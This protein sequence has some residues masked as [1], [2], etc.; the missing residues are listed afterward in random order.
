MRRA[1][2]GGGI[3][4]NAKHAPAL[5]ARYKRHLGI[6]VQAWEGADFA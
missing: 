3:F 5:Q 4:F 2:G 6:D 1:T